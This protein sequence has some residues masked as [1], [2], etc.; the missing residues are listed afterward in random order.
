MDVMRLMVFGIRPVA[1]VLIVVAVVVVLLI[2]RKNRWFLP[3]G[4]LGWIGAAFAA[5][6]IPVAVL[7]LGLSFLM[8]VDGMQDTYA[9][10]EAANGKPFPELAFTNVVGELEDSTA[11]FDGRVVIVNFWATWCPPCAKE[12]P[13]LNRL[14]ETFGKDDLVVLHVSDEEIST[15]HDW[16]D[17]N[18]MVTVHGVIDPEAELP[19]ALPPLS[20]RPTTF[21]IDRDGILR[22]SFMGARSY[23]FFEQRV[24]RYL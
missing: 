1:V 16:L 3:A 4:A 10:L 24:R 12:M 18:P 23:E 13:D 9:A 20:V 8:G 17:T 22:E 15:I 11:S 2:G 5:M 6:L 21:V 14:Q 19:E 7:L